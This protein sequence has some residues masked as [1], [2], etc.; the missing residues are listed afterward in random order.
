MLTAC[1]ALIETHAVFSHTWKLKSLSNSYFS[2]CSFKILA[3]FL[4]EIGTDLLTDLWP[5]VIFLFDLFFWSMA[6]FLWSLPDKVIILPSVHMNSN[7]PV[8]LM[9]E[10]SGPKWGDPKVRQHLTL[11]L[12]MESIRNEDNLVRELA[13]QWDKMKTDDDQLYNLAVILL[14]ALSEQQALLHS[15]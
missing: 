1:V 8:V 13:V 12:I 14:L 11:S 5:S 4:L 6:Y 2:W 9:G 10:G 3:L 7:L 15:A